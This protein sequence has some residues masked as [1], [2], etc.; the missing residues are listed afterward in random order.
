[1][2]K[3]KLLFFVFCFFFLSI[4]GAAHEREVK[5][6]VTAF[7]KIPLSR[8]IVTCKGTNIEVETNKAGCFSLKCDENAKLRIRANG[9]YAESI[10]LKSIAEKDSLKINLRFKK[11][12]KN[13]EIA[14][15]YGH[16]GE[17][18][19]TYAIDHLEADSDYDN[20]RNILEALEGRISGISI[21]NNM[22]NIRGTAT[23]NGGVTPAL[24]VVDG[25]IVEFPVFVN[26]PPT[27]VKSISVIK[28]AAA[29]ARYGSRG[30][31]GV[32]L[33][34]TKSKN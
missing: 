31:G 3:L 33:V 6:K 16:I 22:I 4:A 12:K 30:M 17:R 8:V 11:G 2:I 27:Q 14:T 5:G 13:F 21:G 10:N 34:K 7:G 25:T 15:G 26:I 28:G 9:F 18:Q 19:L 29:S 20:Y 1:M 24:L 32:I 23:L